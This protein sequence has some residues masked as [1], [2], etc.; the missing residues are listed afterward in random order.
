MC[1]GFDSIYWDLKLIFSSSAT[2]SLRHVFRA[3]RMIWGWMVRSGYLIPAFAWILADVQYATLIAVLYATYC[4][5]QIPSNM[6]SVSEVPWS[7]PEIDW[8]TQLLNY[9]TR[10]VFLDT[11]TPLCWYE[12]TRPALYIGVC[13]IGW[14]LT[15]LLTGVCDFK[16]P[17]LCTNYDL[18]QITKDFSGILACRVFIGIPET[19]FYPGAMYLLSRWYTKKV[20]FLSS[21]TWI[22]DS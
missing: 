4:P 5:A 16:T 6:A 8:L 10:Y 14:G 12:F 20:S 22:L 11:R 19:A 18:S 7:H 21:E 1:V 9:V 2:V 13:I 15:S 3:F 17:F